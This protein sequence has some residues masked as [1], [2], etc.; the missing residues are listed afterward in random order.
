VNLGFL[1]SGR[2]S[3]LQA[4]IDACKSGRLRATPRVVISNN[5][6]SGALERARREGIP[7][8]HLSSH[9]HG[10]GLDEAILETLRRHGVELVVLAGY[11]KKLGPRTLVAYRN[12]IVNIHPALLP[13]FGGQ[14][15][16]GMNVHRAVIAAGERESGATVH[17]VDE[18]YDHGA[19]LA[20]T[21]VPV[22]PDDTPE[23]LARRVLEREHTFLVET[24]DQI[25]RGEIR[26]D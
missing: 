9:T 2:G 4:V 5:S 1:A 12:R 14:G 3:N 25:I 15:M 24:L 8:Y 22:L 17:L 10:E 7:A 19:I 11:M 20:Q 18:E 13:K 16:Y 26:L 23:T 21:C 6:D